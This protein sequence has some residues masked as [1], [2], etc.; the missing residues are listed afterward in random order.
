M[1]SLEQPFVTDVCSYFLFIFLHCKQIF[2]TYAKVC[3]ACSDS[4]FY[5]L[6]FPSEYGGCYW[7]FCAINKF[8]H[9]TFCVVGKI[10]CHTD[11][12]VDT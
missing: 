7:N 12:L 5:F 6:Y 4:I 10:I 8:C 1:M 2:A 3:T 9:C 11:K